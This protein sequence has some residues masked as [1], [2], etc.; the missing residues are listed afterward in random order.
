MTV[1]PFDLDLY[2]KVG[3][4]G[5]ARLAS[6]LSTFPMFSTRMRMDGGF[7][8]QMCKGDLKGFKLPDLGSYLKFEVESRQAHYDAVESGSFKTIHM[9]S[10]KYMNTAQVFVSFSPDLKRFYTMA[11]RDV[12]RYPLDETT[13]VSDGNGGRFEDSFANIPRK[14]AMFC[15][16]DDDANDVRVLWRGEEFTPWRELWVPVGR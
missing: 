1:K 6:I 3:K 14:H 5:E 15:A 16:I 4:P 12:K 10:R 9:F 11:M 2:L 8:D 7:T 13:M